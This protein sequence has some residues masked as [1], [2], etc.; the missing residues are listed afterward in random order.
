MHLLPAGHARRVVGDSPEMLLARQRFFAGGHYAPLSAAITDAV[1]T[2]VAHNPAPV[3]V[4]LG[5]GEG[6]HTAA[7]LAGLGSRDGVAAGV[8]LARDA[9][10]LMARRCRD[11][12]GLVA[13]CGRRLPFNDAVVD[14][15]V[16]AFAPRQAAELARVVK[17]GG[18]VVVAL[19]RP[20][21]LREVVEAFGGIGMAADKAE[22]LQDELKDA[23]DVV[24]HVDV[25]ARLVLD[26]PA[27]TDLIGMTPHARH[28]DKADLE[29]KTAT[30]ST[31][32]SASVISFRRR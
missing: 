25:D 29:T 8:D 30:L 21:H 13:D 7:I 23:F 27:L 32:L 9:V 12:R 22:R 1:V 11:A 16:I 18:S 6:S 19:P 17:S 15:T 3:V 28:V 14:V 24:G 4:D 26:G 31:S 5:C 2:A 10:R 20:G